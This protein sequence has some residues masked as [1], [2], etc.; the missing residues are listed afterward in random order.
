LDFFRDDLYVEP[1]KTL[2][3]E[4]GRFTVEEALY[5]E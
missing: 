5:L 1:G 2:A 4:E 3:V